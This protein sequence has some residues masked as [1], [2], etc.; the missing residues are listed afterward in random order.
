MAIKK[1]KEVTKKNSTE[2]KLKTKNPVLPFLGWDKKPGHTPEKIIKDYANEMPE[3]YLNNPEV[4]TINSYKVFRKITNDCYDQWVDKYDFFKKADVISRAILADR[5]E[6][7]VITGKYNVPIF[8]RYQHMY[9]KDYY[10]KISLHAINIQK[11]MKAEEESKTNL[12]ID[13]TSHPSF[14]LFIAN[15]KFFEKCLKHKEKIE[16]ILGG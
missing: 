7:G 12:T 14:Q 13:C 4:I 11:Q 2:K 3:Y 6:T 1:I 8:S 16:S 15:E 5:R 9:D 10:E